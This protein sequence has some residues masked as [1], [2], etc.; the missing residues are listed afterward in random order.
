MP[1]RGKDASEIQVP[2]HVAGGKSKNNLG[3]LRIIH[4]ER[5]SMSE[6][7]RII[8]NRRLIVFTISVIVFLFMTGNILASSIDS[9]QLLKIAAQDERAIIKMPDGKMQLIKAGDV[10]GDSSKVVEITAGR[11]V[12]EEKTGNLT[13]T[14]IIRLEDGK[15]RV[16]RIKK[17]GEKQSQ[18]YAVNTTPHEKAQGKEVVKGNW[19][20][21]PK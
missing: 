21:Q 9:I 13:E 5:P 3:R 8:P 6:L 16:E 11:V 17:A 12:L 20:E 1:R 4:K 7:N 18:F 10:I 19:K 15:Q 14:V 2:P